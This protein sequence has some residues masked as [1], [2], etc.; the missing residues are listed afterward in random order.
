MHLGTLFLWLYWPSFN[1]GPAVG[2]ERHRAVINTIFSL[3]S[4]TVVT[5]ALSA[6]LDKKNKFDMV[7]AEFMLV[8]C[9]YMPQGTISF[10]LTGHK[11]LYFQSRGR[12]SI[13][14]KTGTGFFIFN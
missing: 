12:V 2:N 4:C 3:S 10:C 6:V 9:G 1:A 14:A 8:Y 13:A 11:T 7:H 5:F